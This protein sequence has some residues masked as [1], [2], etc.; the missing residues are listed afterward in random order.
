MSSK[1]LPKSSSLIQPNLFYG[2]LRDMLDMNDSLIAL[3]NAIE[4]KNI[5]DSLSKFL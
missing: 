1:M 3:A 4:W 5:E 2:T